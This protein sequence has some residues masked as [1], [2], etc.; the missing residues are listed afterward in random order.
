MAVNRPENREQISRRDFCH[1]GLR[2]GALAGLG[3]IG[4][5]LLARSTPVCSP[6]G[7]ARC[8]NNNGCR[9]RS[10]SRRLWQIDPDLCIQC[11]RCATACVLNPSAVKCVH[12]F[13]LCGYCELCGGYFR[14]DAKNLDTGAENQLCPT[15]AIKRRYVEEPYFE[16]TIDRDLCIG[17][18]KCV[19]GCGA[20]GNG[21]LYLQILHDRCR[22]CNECAI[23]VACPAAAIKPVSPDQ[24]YLLRG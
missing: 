6:D 10:G 16:Y 15:S 3:V 19:K 20:F 22:H 14:P 24:P 5:R 13:A 21:S 17:C 7:C 23:A 11:G 4:S 2:L 18:G 1:L 9:I 12:S 8:K